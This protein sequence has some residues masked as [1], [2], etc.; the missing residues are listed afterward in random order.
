MRLARI[1]CGL[2]GAS[3][4]ASAGFPR[5]NGRHGRVHRTGGRTGPPVFRPCAQPLRTQRTEAH[6]SAVQRHERH[7]VT[8]DIAAPEHLEVAGHTT[9]ASWTQRRTARPRRGLPCPARPRP[10]PRAWRRSRTAP[11]AGRRRPGAGAAAAPA[12]GCAEDGSSAVTAVAPLPSPAVCA[13]PGEAITRAS[14]SCAA[15][16]ASSARATGPGSPD[17]STTCR[18]RRHQL[19]HHVRQRASGSSL[20][21]SCATGTTRAGEPGRPAPLPSRGARS[22]PCP[23]ARS[24]AGCRSRQGHHLRPTRAS[25]GTSRRKVRRSSG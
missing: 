11:R 2:L 4:T 6:I 17:T 1:L 23:P 8:H 5:N 10:G 12:A 22:P 18:P 20:S 15:S 25:G 7:T 13:S 9:P 14:G 21:T 24:A 3:Q 19:A 16:W